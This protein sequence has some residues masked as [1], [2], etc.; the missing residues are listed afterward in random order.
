MKKKSKNQKTL[1]LLQTLNKEVPKFSLQSVYKS[2]GEKLSQNLSVI[3]KK[4]L[5]KFQNAE[6]FK[7]QLW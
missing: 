6:A 3:N 1:E 2:R 7:R 4:I 5:R